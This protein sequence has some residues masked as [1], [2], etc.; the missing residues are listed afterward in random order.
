VGGAAL[1][2][3]GMW[4]NTEVGSARELQHHNIATSGNQK[5]SRRML[6]WYVVGNRK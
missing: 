2:K 5:L 4:R 6:K 1:G 3:E